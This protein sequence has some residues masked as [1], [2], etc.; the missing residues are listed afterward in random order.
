MT[1]IYIPIIVVLLILLIVV[2]IKSCGGVSEVV[3]VVHD[4]TNIVIHTPPQIIQSPAKLTY[5]KSVT[6]DT[7]TV[8]RDGKPIQITPEE[9][10]KDNLSFEAKS[11]TTVTN[12][13]DTLSAKFRYPEQL[14]SFTFRAKSDTLKQ[15][16][17]TITKLIKESPFGVFVGGGIYVSPDGNIRFGAGINV[18]IRIL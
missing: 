2:S 18:G 11:D 3:K 16:T 12:S 4:T 5:L 14:F 9:Y 1:N 17:T 13:G 7:L 15:I 8:Y 10:C 6:H